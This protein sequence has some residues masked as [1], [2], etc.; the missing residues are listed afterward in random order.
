M[1]Y[2]SFLPVFLS[3]FF[4]AQKLQ[5]VDAEDGRPVPHARIILSNQL[6]YTNEDG[7]AP[8]DKS[9]GNFEVSA[10]GFE[11]ET[12][13]TFRSVVK[14]KPFV[15][16]IEEVE[17]IN[18]D[19]RNI[20]EDVYKNYHKRYYNKP[21]LY[22]ITY[23]SKWFNNDK[24]FFLVIAE[25]KLWS[26]SNMYNFRDGY[27]KNYDKILQMQLNNVKYYKK[28]E[29]ADIFNTVTNEFSH[30][31]MGGYFF[32]YDIYR[33]LMNMRIKGSKTWGRLLS[34]D[35]DMQQIA[36]KVHSANGIVID[37]QFKY[38]KKDKVIT[39]YD[40]MYQQSGYPEY[41]KTNTD[42]KEYRYQ[43]GDVRLTYDFYKK[44]ESYIPAMKKTSGEN[45]F[46][47][48]DSIKDE[49]K[50]STEII[51][52]TFSKSDRDGLESKVDFTKNIWQNV[53]VKENKEA[54]I[55]LSEEEQ[56]FINKK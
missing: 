55:L 27:K 31:D 56:E 37:G 17:I 21:S 15:K 33:A 43:L 24:L 53:A 16:N 35:G 36:I 34:D 13:S 18:V 42:G 3:V 50:F 19:V 39:F 1:K 8:V 4:N 45:F 6:V 7:F 52:N 30:E 51:Y 47:F 54:T 40:I 41:S 22:D 48:H 9:A 29:S 12:V 44:D 46:I 10:S 49:R 5:V 26:K 32:S 23:K 28:D 11:K 2:I 14:L 25:A 38:N 20:F